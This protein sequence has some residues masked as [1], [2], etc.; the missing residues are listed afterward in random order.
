MLSKETQTNGLSSTLN[1]V[2]S[3]GTAW[4]LDKMQKDFASKGHVDENLKDWPYENRRKVDG[5]DPREDTN[6]IKEMHGVEHKIWKEPLLGGLFS[7]VLK[8]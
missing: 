4:T 7:R 6:F 3:L 5:Q 2:I 8:I 1:K